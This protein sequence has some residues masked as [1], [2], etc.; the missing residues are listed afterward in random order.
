M[1]E[2]NCHLLIVHYIYFPLC[3][4]HHIMSATMQQLLGNLMSVYFLEHYK[5]LFWNQLDDIERKQLDKLI[6]IQNYSGASLRRSL[7]MEKEL[8]D[9]HITRKEYK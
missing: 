4:S 2:I 3:L 9:C 6:R 7:V 5:S 8:H 1:Q